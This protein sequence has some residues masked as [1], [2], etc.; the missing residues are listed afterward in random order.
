MTDVWNG[1]P[2]VLYV[3]GESGVGKTSLVHR[4]KDTLELTHPDTNIREGRCYERESVPFKAV[5]S[6]VDNI[7][8]YL[9][10]LSKTEAASML[11]ADLV[12]LP[13]SFPS[14]GG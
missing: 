3:A 4:F 7:S 6:L 9:M 1:K 8:R 12:L 10:K 14:C 13:R 5:D 11:P 2:R